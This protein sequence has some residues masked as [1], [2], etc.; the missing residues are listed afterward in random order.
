MK[1]EKKTFIGTLKVKAKPPYK[2]EDLKDFGIGR[3]VLITTEIVFKDKFDKGFD[4]PSFTECLLKH[5]RQLIE[6]NIKSSGKKRSLRR[7]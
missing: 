6:E 1:N 3:G 7:R 2:K 4:S 5:G